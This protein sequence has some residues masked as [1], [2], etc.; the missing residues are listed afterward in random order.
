[1]TATTSRPPLHWAADY[2]GLPYAP[3]D[4]DCWG[5]F[6]R[7]QRERFGR[8]LPPV[9]I[10]PVN[11][12]GIARAFRDQPERARW[13]EVVVPVE[14]DAVLMAHAKHPSHVGVWIAADGGGVLHCERDAGVVFSRPQALR[15]AGWSRFAYYRRAACAPN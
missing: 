8:D 12:L 13:H 5:F 15:A 14:G 6:R 10:D 4:M 2:I 9:D 1:M 7:V 3:P 11:L